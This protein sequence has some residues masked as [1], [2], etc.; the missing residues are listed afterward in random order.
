MDSD[1]TMYGFEVRYHGPTNHKGSRISV[2]SNGGTKRMY[3]FDYAASDPFY[4]ALQAWLADDAK[5]CD[6]RAVRHPP[7]G[8]LWTFRR[9]YEVPR[10]YVIVAYWE[11]V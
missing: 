5:R 10:G 9:V 8:T 11:S 7:E 1:L 4:S 2:R 6:T 3:S